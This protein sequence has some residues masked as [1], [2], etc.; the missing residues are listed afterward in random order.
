MGAPP[1]HHDERA[2]NIIMYSVLFSMSTNKKRNRIR[3][4]YLR[5]IRSIRIRV[6]LLLRR[7]NVS[8]N[9]RMNQSRS[10]S[11]K[12][13]GTN[14]PSSINTLINMETIIRRNLRIDRRLFRLNAND[15]MNSARHRLVKPRNTRN[16]ILSDKNT[17]LTINSGSRTIIRKTSTNKTRIS[18]SSLTLRVTRN[19]PITSKGKFIRRSSSTTRRITNTF[20]Y[21]RQSNRTRGTNANCST[22][23]KRTSSLHT[24]DGTRGSSRRFM[25]DIRRKTRNLITPSLQTTKNRRRINCL[26][27][28]M[29][30]LTRR[31]NHYSLVNHRRGLYRTQ[32]NPQRTNRNRMRTTMGNR[33]HR[34]TLWTTRRSKH[35][36]GIPTTNL[37]DKGSLPTRRPTS[38]GPHGGSSDNTSDP[39]DRH[40]P[41]LR[42]GEPSLRPRIAGNG[43]R[44]GGLLMSRVMAS[45]PA[46]CRVQP[47]RNGWGE[48]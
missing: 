38:R 2:K 31:R 10:I 4:I 6:V 43:G 45:Y 17:S 40:P 8:I 1:I 13:T 47:I 19:S 44:N 24:N 30:T 9:N 15:T 37:R 32:G 36:N 33:P 7:N 18:I 39:N 48:N 14:R 21:N 20:L 22:T 16:Y 3:T 23:S 25:D 34:E 27:D 26:E 41:T 12:V 46:M 11:T 35:N 42:R 5:R 29:R 28:I